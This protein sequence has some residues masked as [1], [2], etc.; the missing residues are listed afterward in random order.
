MTNFQYKQYKFPIDNMLRI[1][2]RMANIHGQINCLINCRKILEDTYKMGAAW[3]LVFMHFLHIM[4]SYT[5][6]CMYY[7]YIGS[8]K[9]YSNFYCIECI[10]RCIHWQNNFGIR[11]PF[12]MKS[13]S[14]KDTVISNKLC[15]LRGPLLICSP[16]S[17]IGYLCGM[18]LP[19]TRNNYY[20]VIS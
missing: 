13:N 20:L 8:L 19:T 1:E 17:W 6:L 3:E 2:N 9:Y 7:N 5:V 11:E 12:D 14:K 18:N 10:F 16:V 15:H 4:C